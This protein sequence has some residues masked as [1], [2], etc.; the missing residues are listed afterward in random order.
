MFMQRLITSLILVPLVLMTLFYA[1]SWFLA[2]VLLLVFVAAWKESLQLIPINNRAHQIAFLALMLLALWLCGYLFSYWLT[3]GLVLWV[4][5]CIAILGFP[6][7]QRYWGYPSVVG[8]LLLILLPLF[9]QSL[10]HV[11]ELPQGKALVIY[12]LF[13]I[14]ASDVGAYLAGKQ[15]GTHKLIPQVSPGK[16]WE[17]V[18]GGYLLSMVVAGVGFYY[19]MPYSILIWFGLA[20]ITVTISIFGDLFISILKRRCHLKDT[21]TIIPGHGGI[22]DRLDSLI[23]ALPLFYFGLTF[24]PLGI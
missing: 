11:Y 7:S 14:W 13:L 20:F 23:A 18:L 9:I 17:G 8:S 21:G 2:G 24:I 19:F 15:W 3:I 16:S 10:A 6:D 12:L 5:N 1:P 22:L 4:F